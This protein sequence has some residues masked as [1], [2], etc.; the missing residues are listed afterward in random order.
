MPRLA[1]NH[2]LLR[3][4][5]DENIGS[6][7]VMRLLALGQAWHD[8]GGRVAVAASAPGGLLD[9]IASEGWELHQL[10]SVHPDRAD[11]QE[12]R[13]LAQHVSPT[14]I[15][16]DGPHF[17]PAYVAGL[18]KATNT[19]LI[20][21]LAALGAYPATVVLNQN[22]HASNLTYRLNP[23]TRLLT[24]RSDWPLRETPDVA[25]RLMVTFG[26]AD[27]ARL[28]RRALEALCRSVPDAFRVTAI[29]GPI[30]PD[31]P[32][33]VALAGMERGRIELRHNVTDMAGLLAQTDLAL[34][35]GGSTVWEL[36]R[37]GVPS[38]IVETAA[39]EPM[40]VEGLAA[41]GLF[42][43]LGAPDRLTDDVLL[44]ALLGAAGDR[45]W[46]TRMAE[47]GRSIVDGHGAERVVSEIAV[48]V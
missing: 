44:A 14:W 35:S 28:T 40:L 32:A 34:S 30:N 20:D 45:P 12:V 25:R 47:L 22:L 1:G 18:S 48:L 26:G 33:L 29:V 4:D 42:R 2:L 27:P 3:A 13:R 37:M 21:D 16:I 17:D 24:G 31:L 39:A 7:H 43:P 8:A 46:R 41:I 11:L 10:T 15:A 5:A 9:R 6:G 38:L 23:G 36:A 19:L